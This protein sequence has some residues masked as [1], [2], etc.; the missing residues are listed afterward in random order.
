MQREH[1]GFFFDPLT[2]HARTEQDVINPRVGILGPVKVSFKHS[3][4]T[5]AKTN[6]QR[7][8]LM[9]IIK[10]C[11]AHSKLIPSATSGEI[12]Q[13]KV[14]RVYGRFSSRPQERGDSFRSQTEG[15]IKFAAS[16]G[17]EL[18]QGSDG[19]PIFYFDEGVSGKAGANLDKELGRLLREANDGDTILISE[20]DR[21]GRQN[22]IDV[23]GIV[24]SRFIDKGLKILFWKK[25]LLIDAQTIGNPAILFSLFG[26]TTVSFSDNSRK[27]ERLQDVNRETFQLAAKGIAT[28]NLSKYLPT[29]FKWND[30]KK[31]IEPIEEKAKI[32][33]RIFDMFTEEGLG[34]TTICQRL[35][36]EGIPTLY[37]WNKTKAW[38][39]VSLKKILINEAYAGT[40]TVKGQRFT[41]YEG[42][43]S[44]EQYD[45]AQL[46]IERW[47]K[48]A[49][50]QTDKVRINNLFRG[51]AVCEDCGGLLQ[52]SVSLPR[53]PKLIKKG[54]HK[55]EMSRPKATTTFAYRCMNWKLK[56]KDNHDCHCTT[57][58]MRNVTDI[59]AILCGEFLQGAGETLVTKSSSQLKFRHD[60]LIQQIQKAQIAINNL[61]DMV[62]SGDVEAKRRIE[63][64]R[65]EK[66]EMEKELRTVKVQMAESDYTPCMIDRIDELMGTAEGKKA[67]YDFYPTIRQKL[68]DQ[69]W[70]RQLSLVLPTF[71]Q[72]VVI[73]LNTN[74]F[75]VVK[76]DGT[77]T[78]RVDVDAVK[79]E[80]EQEGIPFKMAA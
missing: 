57:R 19:K 67:I 23:L 71:M 56:R 62:E 59:E 6:K 50:N 8:M 30:D 70:R 3:Q 45:K 38:L 66:V 21:L 43:I 20:A 40:M 2:S 10:S 48:R 72:R 44:R 37:S 22:P 65:S 74:E 80:L 42:I 58:K 60:S 52:V 16:H 18:V 28:K 36:A 75:Y 14:A 79:A 4:K 53:K 12:P 31:A 35:N 26:E 39:E 11:E 7:R 54:P 77:K 41:C 68:A 73:N 5:S 15:A 1:V 69:T 34:K 63:K 33:R 25:G 78:K 32:I 64:R 17:Y 46:L 47:R 24:K 29:S 49:G 9:K 76:K 27:I 55:G 51:M 13:M 61:F